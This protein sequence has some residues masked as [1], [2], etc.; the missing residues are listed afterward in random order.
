MEIPA[1]H[2]VGTLEISLL[3]SKTLSWKYRCFHFLKETVV[4]HACPLSASG[5][6]S[7]ISCSSAR[8]IFDSTDKFEWA[9]SARRWQ[10]P[11]LR[12]LS[13]GLPRQLRL[14]NLSSL[15]FSFYL[16]RRHHLYLAVVF[17][18]RRKMNKVGQNMWLA[19]LR[20]TATGWT[21]NLPGRAELHRER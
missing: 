21:F 7:T 3:F 16:P 6:T 10:R 14:F 11:A 13:Q 15:H 9:T 2:F 17:N 1:Y 18:S 20:L 12:R 19:P 8:Q 4:D 5:N